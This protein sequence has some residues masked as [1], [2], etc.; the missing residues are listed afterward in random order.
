MSCSSKTC[1]RPTSQAA[2]HGGG[3]SAAWMGRRG[4]DWWCV[5]VG[6]R[7]PVFKP[8]PK[9]ALGGLPSNFASKPRR[10]SSSVCGS[11][12]PRSAMLTSPVSS[13]T[14]TRRRRSPCSCRRGTVAAAVP[15]QSPPRPVGIARPRRHASADTITPRSGRGC[16]PE[17]GSAIPPQ[18]G[19]ESRPPL[20]HPPRP[21]SRSIAMSSSI[22]PR[23]QNSRF[24]QRFDLS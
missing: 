23:E 18:F 11:G 16:W 3:I 13:L 5:C 12:L 1:R 4:S 17:N 10:P 15:F 6:H 2:R 7:N 21:F 24:D 9:D 14:T 8:L 22:F 20:S 19:V